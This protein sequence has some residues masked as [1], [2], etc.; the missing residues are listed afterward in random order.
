MPLKTKDILECL[1]AVDGVRA[2]ATRLHLLGVTRTDHLTT[3][4]SHGVVSF[5]STSPL[6]S[7]VQGRQGQLLH[8]GPDAYGDPR[9]SRKAIRVCRSVFGRA[10]CPR[11]DESV[12][13]AVSRI[14]CSMRQDASIGRGCR[15]LYEHERLYDPEHD[16]SAAY[17]ETLAD[18]PWT[19]CGCDVCRRL[20]ITSH[21]FAEPSET[22]GVAFTTC[23]CSIDAC[24]VNSGW[25]LNPN[26]RQLASDLAA[27]K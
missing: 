9:A 13:E 10:S 1:R 4:A 15:R 26:R 14:A 16:H 11:N 22:D 25:P 18:Q 17:R 23:G 19:R 2:P 24:D 3:F 12:G 27:T 8:D 6:P 5:D 20:D 21:S 7:G